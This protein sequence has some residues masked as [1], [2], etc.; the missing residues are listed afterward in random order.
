MRRREGPGLARADGSGG[1][2]GVARGT[3]QNSGEH[4]AL[5]V[6]QRGVLN[7]EG[8]EGYLIIF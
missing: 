7:P 3:R 6:K 5:G 8:K 2:K 1:E 4:K